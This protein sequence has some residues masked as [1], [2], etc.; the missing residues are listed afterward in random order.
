MQPMCNVIGEV[1]HALNELTDRV[2]R[3]E[4]LVEQLEKGLDRR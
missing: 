4:T 3:L 2:Q 1:L